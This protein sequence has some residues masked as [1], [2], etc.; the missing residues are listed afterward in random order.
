MRRRSRLK[1][2]VGLFDVQDPRLYR[3]AHAHQERNF[4]GRPRMA[5]KKAA[6]KGAAKKSASKKGAAKKK[7]AKK[8]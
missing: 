8:K 1:K 3:G 7:G 2:Q 4:G 5:M 6:K